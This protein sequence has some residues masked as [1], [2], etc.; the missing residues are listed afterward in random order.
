MESSLTQLQ[1]LIDLTKTGNNTYLHNKL[2][3]LK[4]TIV[5]E[6]IQITRKPLPK[7]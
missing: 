1:H 3:G 7:Q 5:K 6:L 4:K 2:K